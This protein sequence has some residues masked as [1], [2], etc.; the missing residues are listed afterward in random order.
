MIHFHLII[1]PKKI[2]RLISIFRLIWNKTGMTWAEFFEDAVY[3]HSF[4]HLLLLILKRVPEP[5]PTKMQRIILH[6]TNKVN[7]VNC[8]Q[9]RHF[10][11][12]LAFSQHLVAGCSLKFG[13]I[14]CVIKSTLFSF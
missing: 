7:V 9:V 10:M 4:A 6:K 1:N 12:M 3:I 13:N 5:I 2:S 11:Q 8:Q 14:F